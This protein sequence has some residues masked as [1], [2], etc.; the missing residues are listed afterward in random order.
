M[1]PLILLGIGMLGCVL[2]QIQDLQE[3]NEHLERRINLAAEDVGQRNIKSPTKI[4]I[5]R[6]KGKEF[7]AK[8]DIAPDWYR[9]E[10]ETDQRS[11]K[12]VSLDLTKIR[13]VN[14]QKPG[15]VITGEEHL[16]RLKKSGD[17]RLDAKIF[18]TLFDNQDLIPDSWKDR[19]YITFDG[20]IFIG[21]NG[22]DRFVI[23]LQW[24]GSKKEWN[25]NQRCL[26]N[27]WY[28]HIVSAV[29]PF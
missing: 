3:R 9:V 2:Y 25:W 29:F 5:N 22:K 28:P 27:D 1:V 10:N 12:I 18:W 26:A 4:I 21:T 6:S 23:Y 17:V 14:F 16:R 7:F 20:D 11:V 15:E 13:F 24:D 19:G 8:K